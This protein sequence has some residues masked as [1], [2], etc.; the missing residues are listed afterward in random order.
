MNTILLV[1]IGMFI[2]WNF[3]QPFWAK[4]V[5]SWIMN[6]IAKVSESSKNES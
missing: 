5:Q 1:L 4:T 3:P 6:K 2:G